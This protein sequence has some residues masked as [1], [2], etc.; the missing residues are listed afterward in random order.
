MSAPS[1][2]ELLADPCITYRLKAWL[3]EALA[4]DPLDAYYDAL[5]LAEVLKRRM[6]EALGM[7]SSHAS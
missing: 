6:E 4:A 1:V 5:L 7:E 3:R 2:P